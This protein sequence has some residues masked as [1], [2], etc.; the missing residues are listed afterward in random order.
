MGNLQRA[1][2]IGVVLKEDSFGV[3]VRQVWRF[4][5]C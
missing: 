1:V 3:S 4:H 2:G 5:R